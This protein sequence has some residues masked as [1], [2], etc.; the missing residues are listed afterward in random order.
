MLSRRALPLLA[1]SG[2][3]AGHHHGPSQGHGHG[4]GH[5]RGHNRTTS[6]GSAISGGAFSHFGSG[7]PGLPPQPAGMLGGRGS[8]GAAEHGGTPFGG[9]FSSAFHNQPPPTTTNHQRN[10]SNLHK[11]TATAGSVAGMGDGG[12]GGG[13]SMLQHQDSLGAGLPGE[14][15]S[16]L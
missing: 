8:V 4:H 6:G 5:A 2:T 12:G 14:R 1:A 3:G 11:R 7:A 15:P 16:W 10:I 9:P 13:A